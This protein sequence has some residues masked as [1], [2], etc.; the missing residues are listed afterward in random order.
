MPSKSALFCPENILQ[1][2]ERFA[3]GQIPEIGLVFICFGLEAYF[4][5]PEPGQS[6]REKIQRIIGW[7]DGNEP[8]ARRAEDDG[9]KHDGQHNQSTLDDLMRVDPLMILVYR[10]DRGATITSEYQSPQ[11]YQLKPFDGDQ[12]IIDDFHNREM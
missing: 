6:P 12:I 2:C 8:P 9:E 10:R 1:P 7:N 5:V 4:P 11:V 3:A